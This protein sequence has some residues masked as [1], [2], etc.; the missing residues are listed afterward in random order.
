M[1]VV[2]VGL[3]EAVCNVNLSANGCIVVVLVIVGCVVLVIGV[4]VGEVG[5]LALKVVS[6]VG[7]L[8]NVVV[9]VEDSLVVVECGV[10]GIVAGE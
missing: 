8:V 6:E 4:V 9:C 1:V 3:V 10:V 7:W 2:F 5:V